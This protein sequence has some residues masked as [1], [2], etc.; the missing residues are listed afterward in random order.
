MFYFLK[1]VNLM[2]FNDIIHL[3][4]VVIIWHVIKKADQHSTAEEEVV[5]E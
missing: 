5:V 1:R 4:S 2:L 3:D